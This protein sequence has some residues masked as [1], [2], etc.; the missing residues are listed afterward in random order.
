MCQECRHQPAGFP[1]S[2]TSLEGQV[3]NRGHAPRQWGPRTQTHISGAAPHACPQVS[4]SLAQCGCLLFLLG[5]RPARGKVPLCL[6]L[7]EWLS[8]AS[9]FPFRSNGVAISVAD[10]DPEL[11]WVMHVP[12]ASTQQH[13][14][15]WTGT[16]SHQTQ[17]EE[18]EF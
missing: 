13:L 10:G 1:P 11:G 6:S 4:R 9:V 5:D 8:C 17:K 15:P 3:P 2:R 7:P 16:S 18:E 12:R 14:G